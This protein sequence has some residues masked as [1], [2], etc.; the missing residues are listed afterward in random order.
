MIR[1]KKVGYN[2]Y[3]LPKEEKN[4]EGEKGIKQKRKDEMR[5]LSSVLIFEKFRS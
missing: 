4:A 2:G 1:A 5:K 3:L